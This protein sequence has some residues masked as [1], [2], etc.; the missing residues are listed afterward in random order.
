MTATL[1]LDTRGRKLH[2][3]FP[4]ASPKRKTAQVRIRTDILKR[5]KTRADADRRSIPVMV[6]MM[7]ERAL[8]SYELHVAINSP[9]VR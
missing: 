2:H 8:D 5:I 7:L 3:R 1:A 4:M 9:L 6:E